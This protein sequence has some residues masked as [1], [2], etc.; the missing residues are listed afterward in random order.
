[1]RPAVNPNTGQA[2]TRPDGLIVSQSQHTP[3]SPQDNVTWFL[4]AHFSTSSEVYWE[5]RSELSRIRLNTDRGV[6]YRAVR[7]T[8]RLAEAE[9]VAS[10]GSKGDSYDCQSVPVGSTL[11]SEVLAVTA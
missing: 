11:D 3:T 1:M 7:Y 6:Q 9:A 5:P 8:D 2:A 10:V 4:V